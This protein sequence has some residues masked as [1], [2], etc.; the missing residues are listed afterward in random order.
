MQTAEEFMR[1]YF[2]ARTAELVKELAS[3]KLFR[4][5]FFTNDCL[6][7]GRRGSLEG[8]KLEEI[9][10][11]SVSDNAAN[12]ITNG[13]LNPTH[14]HK[15]RYHLQVAGEAWLIQGVDGACLKCHGISG[16]SQCVFCSGTG[17]LKSPELRQEEPP[18]TPSG[19]RDD[20]PP[21]YRRF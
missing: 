6:W 15:L 16:N 2:R 12:V 19:R 10:S 9:I 8:S 1:E 13:V 17:W 4:Q 20:A 18:D 7:D 14:L 11:L 3:R 21:P 5:K